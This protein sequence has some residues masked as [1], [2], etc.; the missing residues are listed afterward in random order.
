MTYELQPQWSNTKQTSGRVVRQRQ[1]ARM[2]PES[3]V[4][5]IHDDECFLTGM[6]RSKK[7]GP[8]ALSCAQM[9]SSIAP[10]RT[11]KQD[12]NHLMFSR[13]LSKRTASNRWTEWDGGVANFYCSF[14][15]VFLNFFHTRRHMFFHIWNLGCPQLNTVWQR[16][17]S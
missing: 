12:V 15:D 5:K 1:N 4:N 6:K 13:Q 9:L 17:L 14:W 10:V 8:D 11:I 7:F 2:F 3:A 16:Q